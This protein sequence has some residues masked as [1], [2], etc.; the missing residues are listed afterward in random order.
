VAVALKAR[1]A[2][3]VVT[4]VVTGL[5]V[6]LVAGV[7]VYAG[8]YDVA[9]TRQHSAPVYWMLKTA[10]R[11]SVR[12]HARNVPVPALGDAAQLARGRLLYEAH[13]VRCHGAPGVSPDAFALGLRPL[14]ANLANTALEWAPEE[15]FWTVRQ[16][17]KTTGMPAWQFRLPDDAVWSIVAYV[18]TLPRLSPRQ[19]VTQGI[20]A[21]AAQPHETRPP[22]P[23]TTG[24]GDAGRG[25]MLF[26]QYG[27]ITCHAIPG[28]VGASVPVGPPLDR[29]GL[30]AYIA[31][32]LQN[33]HENMVRFLRAPQDVLPGGAMPN[34][35]VPEGDAADLAA[36]LAGLQ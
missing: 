19:Y 26:Q 35:G 15:I 4:L 18:Q 33:T 1:A 10:M 25:R 8:I 12:H 24:A 27:C 31:G 11:Q 20:E 9:A 28:V 7:V 5:L 34:L 22:L 29:M 17:I 32:V 6:A 21:R 30:R 13:C 14:P 3:V 16:G 36:Y 23:S 2:T